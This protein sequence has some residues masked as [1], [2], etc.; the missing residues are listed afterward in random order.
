MKTINNKPENPE[1]YSEEDT[2]IFDNTE[3]WIL[4]DKELKAMEL[5]YCL[6]PRWIKLQSGKMQALRC[7]NC[8]RCKLWKLEQWDERLIKEIQSKESKQFVILNID[9]KNENELK[10][11]VKR[12]NPE[13]TELKTYN[14]IATLSVRRFLE[15]WR[16]HT[17]KSVKHW[18]ITEL[19]NR[20]KNK[21]KIH[22]MIHTHDRKLIRKTWKY[23]N[24]TILNYID[25][26]AHEELIKYLSN[27]NKRL[28][29]Y[30]PIILT[31][32]KYG[33]ENIKKAG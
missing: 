2:M 7:E 23:G 13:L 11:I 18:L 12:L 26:K 16:H 14:K 31:S 10:T 33:T 6:N 28:K 30:K 15:L 5:N 3:Q 21:I 19:T 20:N 9:N 24:V 1:I 8:I 17:K 32:A 22:G 29:E 27:T 4:S 25:S